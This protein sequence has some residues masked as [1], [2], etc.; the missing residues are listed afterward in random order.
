MYYIVSP[1]L[2]YSNGYE[3]TITHEGWYPIKQRNQVY[4]HYV[5]AIF[6]SLVFHSN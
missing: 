4:S 5:F 2:F 3:I 6:F 1:L